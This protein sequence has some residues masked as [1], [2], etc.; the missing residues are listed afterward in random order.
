MDET[1]SYSSWEVI[2]VYIQK[3]GCLTI[4]SLETSVQKCCLWLPGQ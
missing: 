3:F 4:S 1:D 2:Q